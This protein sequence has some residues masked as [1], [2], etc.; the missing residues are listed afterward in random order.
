MGSTYKRRTMGFNREVSM[1][2]TQAVLEHLEKY[3]G[4]TTLEAINE[5]GATRLSDIIYRLRNQG[6]NITNKWENG[7]DR[8]GNKTEFVRYELNLEA[9]ENHIPSIY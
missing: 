2:K 4:I 3:G 7:I 5:Y 9:E 8:F 6:H 1:N